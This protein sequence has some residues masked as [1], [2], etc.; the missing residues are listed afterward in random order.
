MAN[1]FRSEMQSVAKDIFDSFGDVVQS[2]QYFQ[3]KAGVYN[4]ATG[5][6][7]ST[8]KKSTVKAI[9]TDIHKE[10]TTLG[11]VIAGDLKAMIVTK[12]LSFK[13][14]LSDYLIHQKEEY[15]VVAIMTDPVGA[16]TTLHLRRR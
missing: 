16:V 9:V 1:S 7:N 4:P 2:Y 6:T 11:E 3:V 8:Q 12:T 14:E 5:S 15:M 13:P 10:Q